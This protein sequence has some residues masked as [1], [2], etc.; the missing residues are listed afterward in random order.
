MNSILRSPLETATDGVKKLKKVTTIIIHSQLHEEYFI[1]NIK[2]CRQ[3]TCHLSRLFYMNI[4]AINSIRNV[5]LH[6]ST[7]SLYLLLRTKLA[8]S[9]FHT[10][11]ITIMFRLPITQG[12]FHSFTLHHSGLVTLETIQANLS[13]CIFL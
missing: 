12:K 3:K 13:S 8:V 4:K 9:Y 5:S 10:L 7:I 11:I 2:P 6:Q 1:I